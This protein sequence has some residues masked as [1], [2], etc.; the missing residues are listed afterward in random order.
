M[1]TNGIR[2][3]SNYIL[4]MI[5]KFF[6]TQRPASS[7]THAFSTPT[8]KSRLPN[9]LEAIGLARKIISLPCFTHNWEESGPKLPTKFK[10][11]IKTLLKTVFF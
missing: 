8:L 4:K 9:N 2:F 1:K 7:T 10:E 3:P 11:G 6:E 5:E